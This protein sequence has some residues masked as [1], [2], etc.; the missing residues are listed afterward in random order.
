MNLFTI[1]AK[2]YGVLG[3]GNLAVS[4]ETHQ[5]LFDVGAIAVLLDSVKTG[6]MLTKRA[7]AFTFNN[8]STNPA[9]HVACERLGVT[10]ALVTLLGDPDKDTNLQATL[11]TRHLCES[12]RFR[13]QFT[14]M[15]GIPVLIALG[16]SEDVEVKREVAAALRNLSLSVHSKV[17][18]VREKGLVLLSELMHS[19]DVEVCHQSSGVIANL[20]EAPENQPIMVDNGII[21][22]L[23]Y[24]LRSKSVDVQR[25]ACRAMAN[26]SA[27]YTCKY[28]IYI[29]PLIL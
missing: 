5:E 11:A 25:E 24:V 4:R 8:L 3:I 20:A 17:V 21:Q 7:A 13:N 23:K 12:A 16:S 22:H 28:P 2:R 1:V 18:M 29:T 9:N 15:N 10:R 26:I 19:P 27:E 14:D 6:D